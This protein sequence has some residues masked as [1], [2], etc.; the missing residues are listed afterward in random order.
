MMSYKL[1]KPQVFAANILKIQ[2]MSFD[3]SDRF[4]RSY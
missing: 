1:M 2:E 4:R 3:A